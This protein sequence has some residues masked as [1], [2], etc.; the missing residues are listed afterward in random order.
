VPAAA[1]ANNSG[2]VRLH[3]DIT[4]EGVPDHIKIEQSLGDAYD[5]EAIRL[6]R[7]VKWTGS[8]ATVSIPFR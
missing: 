7:E 6:V 3:F 4:P 2:N 5:Q 1:P 8:S